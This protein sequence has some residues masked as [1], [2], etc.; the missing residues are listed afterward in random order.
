VADLTGHNPNVFYE[1]AVCHALKKP[2]IQIL[3]VGEILPFDLSPFRTI[4]LDH[5][6]LDSVDRAKMELRTQFKYIEH[7]PNQVTSPL[8]IVPEFSNA[9]SLL[10]LEGISPAPGL[11]TRREIWDIRTLI[12]DGHEYYLIGRSHLYLPPNIDYFMGRLQAGADLRIIMMNIHNPAVLAVGLAQSEPVGEQGQNS[13]WGTGMSAIVALAKQAKSAGNVTV[14]LVD[15]VSPLYIEAVDIQRST[16]VMLIEIILPFSAYG[17]RPVLVLNAKDHAYWF[18]YMKERIAA[19]WEDPGA[20]I[21]EN[22]TT[23]LDPDSRVSE[24]NK[25]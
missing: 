17:D 12:P 19:I 13:F 15:Y 10:Y 2:V 25:S 20:K 22:I 1:L 11:G 4:Q 24:R 9:L 14:K 18:H 5:R 7:N 16:G 21:I 3:E 8:S 6:D 23:Y